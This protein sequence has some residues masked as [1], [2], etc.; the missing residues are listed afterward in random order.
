[1]TATVLPDDAARVL[2]FWFEEYGPKDWFA[3]NAA[4]DEAIRSRFGALHA[5]AA[6]GELDG[7]A[8]T[9]AGALAL[10]L[11]LDQFSRNLFRASAKAFACDPKALALAR[12]AVA[13]GYI[14]GFGE[15]ERAFFLLPFEHSEDPADQE[16]S[17][18]HFGRFSDPLY[19]D[20]AEKHKAIID[21]FGRY[22]HR[23]AALG[24]A[25]TLE[26]IA[27]LAGPG[28]SF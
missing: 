16:L 17:V 4:F 27:F 20:A 19:R 8:E 6:R 21:R 28:S 1:M 12:R 24:R 26:E 7:W 22:P 13:K 3:K 11:V 25:S 10:I 2:H 14:D 9:P 23:N 5:G 15:A 18:R